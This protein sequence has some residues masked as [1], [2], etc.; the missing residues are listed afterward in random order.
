[1]SSHSPT[2]I[3]ATGF[4]HWIDE[5]P[6]TMRP[7]RRKLTRTATLPPAREPRPSMPDRPEPPFTSGS[8]E[9][10]TPVAADCFFCGDEIERRIDVLICKGCAW[11]A[12]HNYIGHSA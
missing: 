2:L 9:H 6:T 10:T 4:D 5:R 12:P 11:R 8:N 1:M 3:V 7:P